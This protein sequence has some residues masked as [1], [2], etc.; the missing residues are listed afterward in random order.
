MFHIKEYFVV[1]E[2]VAWD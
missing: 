1:T 2:T